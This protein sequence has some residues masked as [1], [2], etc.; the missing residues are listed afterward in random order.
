MWSSWSLA[1]PYP[2]SSIKLVVPFEMGGGGDTL[3]R[4][5]SMSVAKSLN[6]N[7][8]VQNV[9][10][11][12]RNSAIVKVKD[13][14][15]DGY[16]LLL[17][18]IGMAANSALYRDLKY[19]PLNDFEYIGLIANVPM[20]LL[21]T[22]DFPSEAFADYVSYAKSYDGNLPK[23]NRPV[24]A[25]SYLCGLLFMTA[26]QSDRVWP[27]RKMAPPAY[28]A[29]GDGGRYELKC[30][31]TI[32][33][34]DLIKSAKYKTFG[35]TSSKRLSVLPNVPSF[36]EQGVIG[37]SISNWYAAYAPKKTPKAIV[38][39]LVSVFQ[40][41]LRDN[42]LVRKLESLGALPVEQDLA[43]PGALLSHLELE[44][45]KW[46]LIVRNSS[47]MSIPDGFR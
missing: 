35:V 46:N 29:N 26:T 8:S 34:I 27:A 33:V 3:A 13:A 39:A 21:A 24:R 10:G 32:S 20:V 28:K 25:D 9:S 19:D 14:V 23:S 41:T 15:P 38:N 40:K 12:E 31:Q 1:E 37:L 36:V 45:G 11:G 30:E 42:D 5:F 47:A 22:P 44:M 16:M 7:V 18:D 43:T 4:L 17:N 2:M 6:Q